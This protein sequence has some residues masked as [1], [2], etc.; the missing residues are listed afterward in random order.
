MAPVDADDVKEYNLA[1]DLCLRIGEVLLAN[2]A[3]AADVTSTMRAV[4][5]HLGLRNSDIDVTYTQISMSHQYDQSE[6]T[7][8]RIRAIT[9]RSFNYGDLTAV[10]HLVR[11]LTA[12]R[13][14]L[15]TARTRMATLVS[16]PPAIPRWAVTLANGVMSAAV[17]MALG[18]NAWV[19]LV[20]LLA[21]CTIDRVMLGLNRRRFPLFYQQVA[22]GFVAATFGVLVAASELDVDPSLAITAN[23]IMLL[24]GIGFMGALQDA[25]S[26]FHLTG[27][28]RITEA[29]MATVGII[30]GVS[31]GIAFGTVLGVGHWHYV[32]GRTTQVDLGVL[33][34]G[35]GVA[36]AAFALSA[37]APAR[38]LPAVAVLAAMA[39]T[40]WRL[41]SDT[42]LEGP[43]APG[44]SALLVGL[45]SYRLSA[46]LRVPP[47]VL[48]VPVLVPLL[49]GLAIYRG[50]SLLIEG[51]LRVSEGLL[52]MVT[53]ASV[54]LALA[55]G[56]ILGEFLAQPVQRESRRL[57]SRLAGPRLVGVFRPRTR[58]RRREIANERARD[59]SGWRNL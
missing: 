38:V 44:I 33:V 4:A 14:D 34:L 51:G 10:D 57:E 58:A 31:G 37:Y 15:Y 40:C 8:V 7:L 25:I 18:G 47:L 56:V 2:G 21:A 30:A 20:A 13:I 48:V 45:I 35:A 23:I 55:A 5:Q 28:A 59:R 41:V 54:A 11:D 32:P 43:W 6:P 49:P 1:I 12:G 19:A 24:A 42:G 3:G 17:G 27:T 22:G 36:A 53:A 52:A 16:T 29:M 46:R 50:L 39:V 26:G 9:T